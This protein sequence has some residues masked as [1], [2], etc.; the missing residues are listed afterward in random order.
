MQRNEAAFRADL[1]AA[2]QWIGK[3]YD[4]R[5]RPAMNAVALL[6]GLSSN[7]LTIELPTLADSLNA[8]RNFRTAREQV[9][10]AAPRK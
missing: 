2:Q 7:A 8:V 5:A 10:V 1:L 6:K 3:H 4:V 9:P